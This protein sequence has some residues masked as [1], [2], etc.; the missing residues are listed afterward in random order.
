MRDETPSVGK[1]RERTTKRKLLGLMIALQAAGKGSVL[2]FS[3]STLIVTFQHFCYHP[4]PSK[5]GTETKQNCRSIF[6]AQAM[7]SRE[8]KLTL[9][10]F[11][12]ELQFLC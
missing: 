10:L 1:K 4:S 11:L 6:K 5:P 8:T 9:I 3:Q 2:S 7:T 12:E